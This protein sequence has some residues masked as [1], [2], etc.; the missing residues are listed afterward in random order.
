M[1][2]NNLPQPDDNDP[3]DY[4]GPLYALHQ[5]ADD[6]ED[7]EVKRELL[8]QAIQAMDAIPVAELEPDVRIDYWVDYSNTLHKYAKQIDNIPEQ[9]SLLLKAAEIYRNHVPED[10]RDGTTWQCCFNLCY[11][12]GTLYYYIGQADNREWFLRAREILIY[13]LS[14]RTDLQHLTADICTYLGVE[15]GSFEASLLHRQQAVNRHE[16]EFALNPC[17]DTANDVALFKRK[18]AELYD[19]TNPSLANTLRHEA[20]VLSAKFRIQRSPTLFAPAPLQPQPD[21]ADLTRKA[22]GLKLTG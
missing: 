2:H 15:P 13:D 12:I 18:L 21:I 4:L 20:A 7:P 17:V 1:L 11:Y 22:G 10:K 8:Y 5:A 16:R 14:H 9:L 3:L 19:Q 6:S